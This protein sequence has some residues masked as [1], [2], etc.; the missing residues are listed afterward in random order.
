MPRIFDN[1][2]AGLLPA[3]RDTLAVSARGDFCVGYSSTIPEPQ[4]ICSL[5][6]MDPRR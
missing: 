3:L 2:D 1:I 4:I 5:G 6:L